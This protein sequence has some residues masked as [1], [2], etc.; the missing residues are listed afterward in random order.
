[1]IVVG[2]KNS[3]NSNRLRELAAKFGTRAYLVDTPEDLK[4]SWFDE[5][6]SCGVTAGAS[7]PETLVEQVIEAIKLYKVSSISEFDGRKENIV[8]PIPAELRIK[9]TSL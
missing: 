7:A 5:V 2:S 8:F 4:P 3:S 6:G 9:S 1:M